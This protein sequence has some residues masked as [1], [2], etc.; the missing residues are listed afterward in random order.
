MKKMV[1]LTLALF[2]FLLCAAC[3][4][5]SGDGE[6]TAVKVYYA[7]RGRT[8]AERGL[9]DGV[10]R[11]LPAE[12]DAV[13]FLLQELFRAP[14]REDLYS[15]YP[16]GTRV[17]SVVQRE[18]RV[19]LRLSDAYAELS[20]LGETIADYCIV[21]TLCQLEEVDSVSIYVQNGGEKNQLR[22]EDVIIKNS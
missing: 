9:I 13:E 3:G 22:P 10:E 7:V 6:E 1:A 5:G 4:A 14:E 12:Q 2:L 8:Q 19:I 21:L 18:G 17:I 15:P 20:G 11:S 16:T